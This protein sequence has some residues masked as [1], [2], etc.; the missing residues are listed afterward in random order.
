MKR[1]PLIVSSAAP[2]P[3]A[4]LA[5][6]GDPS[7][8]LSGDAY[9]PGVSLL[10]AHAPPLLILASLDW[11]SDQVMLSRSVW[12]DVIFLLRQRRRCCFH[13][14]CT[15]TSRRPWRPEL[16]P[17]PRMLQRGGTCRPI[18]SGLR[19]FCGRIVLSSCDASP[20]RPLL[21]PWRTQQRKMPPVVDGVDMFIVTVQIGD[22]LPLDACDTEKI[23]RFLVPS[24]N[25]F[26]W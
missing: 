12:R 10:A 21:K 20:C 1:D 26:A 17:G 6:S 2:P 13:F 16:P 18:G 24:P 23:V 7:P 4:A 14:P 3:A 8:P 5:E 15:G 11:D 19:S 25:R 22:G 9:P